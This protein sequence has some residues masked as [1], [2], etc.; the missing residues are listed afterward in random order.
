MDRIELLLRPSGGPLATLH[1]C[2]DRHELAV[3]LELVTE[4]HASVSDAP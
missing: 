2:N 3:E 4:L 1:Y